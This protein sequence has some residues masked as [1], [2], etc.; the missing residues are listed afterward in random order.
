MRRS[1][2]SATSC[3]GWLAPLDARPLS[4]LARLLLMLLRGYKLAISPL[5]IG[6]CRF[7]PGC[8]D[9]TAEAIVRFGALH[10]CWLG[11]RRLSRCHP[12]GGSGFDPVPGA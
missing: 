2:K 1:P 5:F 10:G 9:Y 8:A 4:L 3:S 6:R 7:V 12:A 11:M